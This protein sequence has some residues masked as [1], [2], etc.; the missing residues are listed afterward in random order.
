MPKKFLGLLVGALVLIV[1]ASAGA[2]ISVRAESGA[3]SALLSVASVTP[4]TGQVTGNGGVF[5]CSGTNTAAG[6]LNAA[7]GGNWGGQEF[8]G[9]FQ[10]GRIT[11]VDY[12][13]A[14]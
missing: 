7:T 5:S 3:S 9:D 4:T 13:T 1:P 11:S 12:T 2:A 14:S 8:F 10:F 6:A